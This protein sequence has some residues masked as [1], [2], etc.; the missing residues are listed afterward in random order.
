MDQ[1]DLERHPEGGYYRETYRANVVVPE[2]VLPAGFAGPRNASTAIYYLL[3]AGHVSALHRIPSDEVWHWYA[4][5]SL[6]IHMLD[7]DG[8]RHDI[9][10]GQSIADACLPQVVVPAGVWF[11]AT[12]D[13]PSLYVLAGC[14]VAPGFDFDDFE[15]GD[16]SV[17]RAQFPEH[18]ALIESLS[19]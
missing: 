1:L 5:G 12:V 10:L 4:G 15:P 7:D 19:T 2:K 17:L 3:P 13:D 18:I 16:R 9:R 8:R 14:T 11:G 6:T